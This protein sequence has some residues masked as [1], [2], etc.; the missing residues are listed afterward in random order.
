MSCPWMQK[1]SS[2]FLSRWPK[3]WNTLHPRMYGFCNLHSAF[4]FIISVFL[5][6]SYPLT[7]FVVPLFCM[8]RNQFFFHCK[9]LFLCQYSSLFVSMGLLTCVC[10]CV[11][12]VSTGIL[13]PEM[14]CWLMAGWQR[15]VILGWLETSQLMPTMCFGA[16][17]VSSLFREIQKYI[18]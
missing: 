7:S 17:W 2:A 16:T 13:Q 10:V 6:S 5:T 8:L 1:T 18:T 11:C 9:S 4:L 3:E 15:S 12:S 14:F